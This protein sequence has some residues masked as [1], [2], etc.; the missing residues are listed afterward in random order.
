MPIL[1]IPLSL[2]V[3]PGILQNN[4]TYYA[5]VRQVGT[6]LGP[7]TWSAD[8]D[9]TTLMQIGTSFQGGF[10][11]GTIVIAGVT[12]AV[13]TAPALISVAS[14]VVNPLNGTSQTN[15]IPTDVI[16]S[17]TNTTKLNANSSA[18]AQAI[19]AMSGSTG[20]GY[21]DW[22]IPA[23]DVFSVIA[24]SGIL[25]SAAYNNMNIGSFQ[26]QGNTP[27]FTSTCLDSSSSQT[28]TTGGQPIYTTVNSVQSSPTYN[29][30]EVALDQIAVQCP[31]GQSVQNYYFTDTGT[32]N[33]SGQEI[34]TEGWNCVLPTQ[35]QTGTTPTQTNTN[36]TYSFDAILYTLQ[37]NPNQSSNNFTFLNT[38]TISSVD[39][40]QNGVTL[41]VRLVALP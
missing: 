18:V 40:T 41:P 2:I 3:P 6:V 27:F 11:A 32:Q 10:F 34:Y 29:G 9:F 36:V 33:G 35:V 5:R 26:G 16:N 24:N 14:S 15:L 8:C 25:A 23:A 7:S 13:V 12:Y 37:N 1:P 20:Y 17:N 19:L 31:S 30:T 38:F 39:R 22:Q 4:T 21:N 28:N